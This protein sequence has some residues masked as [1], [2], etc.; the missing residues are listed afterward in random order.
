MIRLQGDQGLPF[1]SADDLRCFRLW[2]PVLVGLR[3][4]RRILHTPH[5]GQLDRGRER[6]PG[7]ILLTALRH[8]L[9]RMAAQRLPL[10]VSP[11]QAPLRDVDDRLSTIAELAR[12]LS[13]P[14]QG[15][16]R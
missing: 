14:I 12:Q 8:F 3:A 6:R 7:R 13:S 4:S 1:P 9:L 10:F 11:A 16:L 15:A 5:L 2:L